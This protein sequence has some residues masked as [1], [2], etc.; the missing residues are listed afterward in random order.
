MLRR[1][2]PRP[3]VRSSARERRPLPCWQGLRSEPSSSGAATVERGATV[4]RPRVGQ[5]C[6]EMA[7]SVRPAGPITTRRL[8]R[9]PVGRPQ[10]LHVSPPLGRYDPA[11]DAQVRQA[12]RGLSDVL[13]QYV[14]DYGEPGTALAGRQ[15]EDYTTALGDLRRQS[16]YSTEDINQS[17]G[18]STEDVNTSSG[19]TLA[20]LQQSRAR[21]GE[22]YG[23]SLQTLARNYQRL[24]SS[25]TQN[26]RQ[27]GVQRGGA[28][29]QA[30]QKRAANQAIDKAPIDTNFSRFN[31]DNTTSQQRTSQDQ[32]TQLG[33][34]GA[35]R[36]T[37]L[38]RLGANTASGTNS[39]QTQYLRG[40]ED[41]ATQLTRAQREN[42]QF[43]LDANDLR[44][45]QAHMRIPKRKP[46][47]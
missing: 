2:E 12:D 39:L 31:T 24:G 19:R 36:S 16:G 6:A 14:T 17:A 30:L 1:S 38:T 11:I 23:T 43:G 42:T 27:A 8:T 47:P 18:R 10:P 22:D 32:A 15:G 37:A 46:A 9:D 33:R 45:Y 26:A 35:D 20:D 7:L 34:I 4:R 25:Q 3:C 5:V 28:L 44:L 21:A 41:A 13:S 40:G 29:A